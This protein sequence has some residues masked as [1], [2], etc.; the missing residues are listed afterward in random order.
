[1][2][3][4]TPLFRIYAKRRM[5]QL[6]AERPIAGQERQLLRLVARA[7]DTRFGRDHDF[8]RIASVRDF[9][10]RVPLRRYE[11]FWRH[12]WHAAFPRLANLTWPGTV[13]YFAKTSGTTTGVTK[14]VPVSREMIGSNRRAALDTLVHHLRHR[15]H[16]RVLGGKSFMLG[17]STDLTEEAPGILSGDLSGIAAREV[18]LWARPYYFPPPD[19]ALIS[20]WGRK[21]DILGTRSLDQDI[22]TISGTA[23]WLL[24]YFARM[25]ELFPE[26]GRRAVD[27]YPRFELLVHGGVNFAPYRTAFERLLDGGRAELREVYP[28]SEGFVAVADRGTGE[29][30]RLL[31]DSG[32]FFEFV[33]VEELD[34]PDPRR[35]WLGDIETGVNYALVL[36]TCAGV[37]A[38]VLGDTVRFV[39]RDPPR[40]L[41]TGRTSYSLSAFGEHLIGEEIERAVSEAADALGLSVHDFSVGAIHAE[42]PGA[43]GGHL[44]VLEFADGDPG[45]DRLDAFA[46]RVD[47]S[48]CRLNVDY[49]DHRGKPGFGI[50]PP[51]ILP[52]PPGTF[53]AWM[54]E[55][56]KLGGQ[57]K[58]PRIVNDAAL[59]QNLRD[60]AAGTKP[61]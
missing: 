22:R 41:I 44:Y 40:L 23:S 14:Y 1:M 45:G 19:L 43:L 30:L 35:F 46:R 49:R 36:S 38:Y 18:P 55:R 61:R 9:Q 52:A 26:R 56:G 15:P 33:P 48:L 2:L 60:F 4:A 59:F 16:S 3:D 8:G 17:G 54:R 29:G 6:D 10:S 12:Y 32:I 7:R 11:D 50:D 37:W 51:R 42:S 24:L 58:V 47:E 5:A 53:A 13:P 39:E 34:A 20:E 57:N 25:A 28:A 21:V 27:F 31:T